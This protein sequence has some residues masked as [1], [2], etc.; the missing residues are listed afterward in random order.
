MLINLISDGIDPRCILINLTRDGIYPRCMLI[1]LIRDGIDSRCVLFVPVQ[2]IH[3]P[4][5]YLKTKKYEDAATNTINKS[6]TS[7]MLPKGFCV[8]CAFCELNALSTDFFLFS[9]AKTLAV[10]L[11]L[12]IKM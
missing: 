10:V 9:N 7:I 4:W 6:V 2:Y 8:F 12:L 1:N 11:I 5:S 3:Y